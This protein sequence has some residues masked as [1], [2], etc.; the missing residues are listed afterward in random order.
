MCGSL[1][2][3]QSNGIVYIINS[4]PNMAFRDRRMI[5]HC[6][7][8]LSCVVHRTCI[9]AYKALKNYII[10]LYN[11]CHA[12][13][14]RAIYVLISGLYVGYKAHIYNMVPCHNPRTCQG[15]NPMITHLQGLQ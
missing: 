13:Y 15:Y 3:S 10:Q 12:D 14:M 7:T 11:L 2:V 6:I 1:F 4:E 5:T 8:H 9:V